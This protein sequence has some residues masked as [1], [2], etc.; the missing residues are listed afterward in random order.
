MG[1]DIVRGAAYL[2]M[3]DET[4]VQ[5]HMLWKLLEDNEITMNF[6]EEFN[7]FILCDR[8][9]TKRYREVEMYE[10]IGWSFTSSCE[11]LADN[12][13][14]E[15]DK[16]KLANFMKKCTDEGCLI[17]THGWYDISYLSR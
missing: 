12:D 7:A 9:I 1:L 11:K 15:T 4:K 3:L 8:T 2:I 10:P 14:P 16:L 13:L 5:K 6:I 17:K